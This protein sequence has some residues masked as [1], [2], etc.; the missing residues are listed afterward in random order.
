MVTG[1]PGLGKTESVT[2]VLSQASCEVVSINANITRSLREVQALI[3]DRI[4]HRKAPKNLSTQALIRE[5]AGGKAL[6][7][8]I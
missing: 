3:Y 4:T 6:I 8:Y 7:V 5:A 1:S 2:R